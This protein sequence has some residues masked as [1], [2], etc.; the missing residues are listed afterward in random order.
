MPKGGRPVE[1]PVQAAG[2]RT[3]Q[4]DRT[5]GP[6]H[7]PARRAMGGTRVVKAYPNE[8]CAEAVRE[9]IEVLR[10]G[11]LVAFPTETVY[12]VGAR[13][14]LPE[15]VAR[16]RRAKRRRPETPFTIHIGRRSEVDRF[17]P[18]LSGV[19][20]RLVA[21]GWPGPLTLVFSGIDPASAPVMA[22]LDPSA[23]SAMYH[24]GSIGLRC[25]DDTTAA[26]LLSGVESPVAAA[27]ANRAGHRPPRTADQ[28]LA[29]LDGQ[30][31]LLVDAGAARYAKSSTV[32]RVNGPG[33]ELVREGVY[34]ART[35]RR[36]AMLN[37]LLVCTGNTCRSPMAAALLSQLLADARGVKGEE[38]EECD[39]K[40]TSAGT[41]ATTVASA[42]GQAIEVMERRGL[43]IQGHRSQ[44]LTSE[45][46]EQADCIFT[47]TAS[48][49]DTVVGMVPSAADR[50]KRVD[51]DRDITDPIGQPVEV[52]AECA[53]AIESALKTRVKEVL[54]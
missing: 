53:A 13:A 10:A 37:I 11:G 48:H 4:L 2:S 38:S 22:D 9:G 14:D 41:F 47:M 29:D 5:A 20:R 50:C 6:E 26:D 27:S 42:S 30:I 15:S 33:Y 49:R 43:D 1:S 12:G 7:N 19:G 34:D 28:V 40:V 3:E 18:N 39:F 32:V 51:A 54:A 36:L 17:V 52:Y 45:L 21:K 46:I 25:P 35:V 16:L 31:D 8:D 44:P 23:A 24:E